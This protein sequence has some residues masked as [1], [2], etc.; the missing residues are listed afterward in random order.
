MVLLLLQQYG[1][2]T[3]FIHL[4]FI[5]QLHVLKPNYS[6]IAFI[7][8][9]NIKIFHIYVTIN[10]VHFYFR[11]CI[12]YFHYKNLESNEL[13]INIC[14][15]RHG[16]M[17]ACMHIQSITGIPPRSLQPP[18]V[19]TCGLLVMRA[20]CYI[21]HR[22][23]RAKILAVVHH[24]WHHKTFGYFSGEGMTNLQHKEWKISNRAN[25]LSLQKEH[26]NKVSVS[27]PQEDKKRTFGTLPQPDFLINV[28]YLQLYL[29]LTTILKPQ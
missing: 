7:L 16:C 4:K 13:Y 20:E 14:T 5:K 24:P 2:F 28:A 8:F 27:S 19:S 17:H 6:F 10:D 25:V 15:Y 23:I 21:S 1:D 11:R 3:Q 12:I 9:Y 29:T 18:I 22:V 26:A